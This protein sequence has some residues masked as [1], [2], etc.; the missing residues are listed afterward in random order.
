[1]ELDANRYTQNDFASEQGNDGDMDT[2]YTSQGSAHVKQIH[3][4]A[5]VSQSKKWDD[6]ADGNGDE[7]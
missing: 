3:R 1:M 4:V 2:S 6:E 7:G 5:S